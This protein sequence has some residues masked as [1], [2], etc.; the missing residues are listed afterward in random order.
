M[1]NKVTKTNFN[2]HCVEQEAMRLQEGEYSLSKL[3]P[4]S[5]LHNTIFVI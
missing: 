4:P 2:F 3:K 5:L 1:Y